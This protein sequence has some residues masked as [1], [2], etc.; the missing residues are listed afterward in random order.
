MPFE[1]AGIYVGRILKGAKLADLP[2]E[3]ASKFEL[4]INMKTTKALGLHGANFDAD[5]RR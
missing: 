2:I 5:S 1:H 4:V 3:L